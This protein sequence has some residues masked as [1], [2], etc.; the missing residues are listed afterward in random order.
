ML[1][2]AARR[3]HAAFD[4]A[5]PDAATM[6]GPTRA[7]LHAELAKRF[8]DADVPATTLSLG[9]WVRRWWLAFVGAAAGVAVAV[10]L[11]VV[12]DQRQRATA[13]SPGRAMTSAR[14][15]PAPLGQAPAL[16]PPPA[17]PEAA[18]TATNDQAIA[19]A[20]TAPAAKTEDAP[21][22]S[23]LGVPGPTRVQ[24]FTQTPLALA[25]VVRQN[26]VPARR[27]A[28]AT[29]APAPADTRR[30]EAAT[31]P[32]SASS[33]ASPPTPLRGDFRFEQRGESVRVV[34]A[35]GSVYVGQVEPTAAAKPFP[36]SSPANQP[37]SP[38]ANAPSSAA[39]AAP[40]QS[41]ENF[42][43]RATGDNRTLRK[44]VVF[45]GEYSSAPATDATS[46][47]RQPAPPVAAQAQKDARPS[48]I[49]APEA[50]IRGSVRVL[51][52]GRPDQRAAEVDARSVR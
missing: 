1:R 28:A 37:G 8:D 20:P 45:E 38:L 26:P 4:A 10:A 52:G 33:S 11:F 42:R 9:G 39:E 12:A 40:K 41:E 47:R 43:F 16:P 17:A 34:D 31:P 32:P 36:G 27:A 19:A 49:L 51:D 23:A 50:Q 22:G 29:P 35:D 7:R 3:R 15:D 48:P 30:Q 18:A 21:A 2:D 44:P 24:T 6:P 14:S 46:D 5:G 13:P 25:N